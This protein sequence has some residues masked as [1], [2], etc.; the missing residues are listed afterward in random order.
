[1]FCSLATLLAATLLLARYARLLG[2]TTA[3]Q[4]RLAEWQRH[5]P[6]RLPRPWPRFAS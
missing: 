4:A 3:Q 5:A 1:V 2:D 6:T